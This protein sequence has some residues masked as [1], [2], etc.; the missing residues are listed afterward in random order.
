MKLS[1][2][3]AYEG[4]SNMFKIENVC[5]TSSNAIKSL[6]EYPNDKTEIEHSAGI[7]EIN[8]NDCDQK[9]IEQTKPSISTSFIEHMANFR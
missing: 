3:A 5:F 9:Y 1:Y 8:Y 7:Y 2:H 4:L 6:L